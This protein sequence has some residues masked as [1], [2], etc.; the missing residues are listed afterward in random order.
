M[1]ITLI[2]KAEPDELVAGPGGVVPGVVVGMGAPEVVGSQSSSGVSKVAEG[3]GAI[4]VLLE[5][6]SSSGA[7]GVAEGAGA[8]VVLW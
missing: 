4:V 2:L 5:P 1:Y 7:L 8:T 6:Q 3:A